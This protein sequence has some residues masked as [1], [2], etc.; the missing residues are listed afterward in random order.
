MWVA[1][2]LRRAW[3][4]VAGFT[5]ADSAG[6]EAPRRGIWPNSSEPAQPNSTQPA[7]SAAQ[8][9]PTYT[10][11]RADTTSLT[12]HRACEIGCSLRGPLLRP[13]PLVEPRHESFHLPLPPP[14]RHTADQSALLGPFYLNSAPSCPLSR[15]IANSMVASS[16]SQAIFDA[17]GRS[18]ALYVSLPQGVA[19][20]Y[21]Y[22]PVMG[23]E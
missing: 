16:Q 14:P 20:E 5:G 7:S 15:R 23:W 17:Q 9:D 6:P 11:T 22:S 13:R 19:P 2:C 21:I 10:A 18:R 12:Y 3:R 8:P 1:P 4:G